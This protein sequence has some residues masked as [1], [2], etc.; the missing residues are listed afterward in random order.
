[1][2]AHP[3]SQGRWTLIHGR[4]ELG[5]QGGQ[6]KAEYKRSNPGVLL[7]VMEEHAIQTPVQ[8]IK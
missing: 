4:A 2:Q 1:M 8:G 5:C 3:P 6:G 7:L